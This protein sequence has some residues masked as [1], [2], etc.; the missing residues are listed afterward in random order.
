MRYNFALLYFL[1]VLV[2]NSLALSNDFKCVYCLKSVQLSDHRALCD[3]VVEVNLRSYNNPGSRAAGNNGECCDPAAENSNLS[4]DRICT[5]DELCD[6]YF[7]FCLR[8]FSTPTTETGGCITPTIL[9]TD[10]IAFNDDSLEFTS[11]MI[12]LTVNQLWQVCYF[13]NKTKCH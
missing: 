2:R 3:Y 5:E 8:P 11:A 6:N 9:T 10:I 12:T 7:S 1:A 4:N 13:A